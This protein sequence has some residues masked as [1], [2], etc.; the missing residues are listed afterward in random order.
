MTKEEFRD[1]C[2]IELSDLEIGYKTGN[3]KTIISSNLNI[4]IQRGNLICLTGPNGGGKSTLLRTI[5][6]FLR[7][8]KGSIKIRGIET[9]IQNRFDFTKDIATVLTTRPAIE[10]TTV[11]QL[12]AMGRIPHTN[13][14]G[15]LTDG[16]HEMI[17]RAM[18]IT[19]I[20]DLASKNIN[21]LSDGER[22]KVMI[23]RAL[24]QDTPI[25]LL[26]EPTAFLDYP[27]KVSIIKL[28]IA[29]CERHDKTIIFSTHDLDI[30][31]TLTDFVWMIDKEKGFFT[32]SIPDLAK[33]NLINKF[34]GTPD[35]MFDPIAKSF[36]I[37]R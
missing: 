23:A 22:Q 21:E 16:D 24:A 15:K 30:A 5:C 10:N 25:I 12:I 26:D 36:I 7:P 31:F 11:Y 28:L 37:T 17:K 3:K 35:V 4:K 6:G 20:S 18:E 8:L 14:F 1:Q 19:A 32:G 33:N 13:F 2:I 9:T 29:L 27:S 34:F